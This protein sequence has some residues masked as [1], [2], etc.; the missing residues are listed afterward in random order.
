MTR[1]SDTS[2]SKA[3]CF[4]PRTPAP[5]PDA[6]SPRVSPA[7]MDIDHGH[8]PALLGYRVQKAHWR[9]F[10]MFTDMLT[11]LG[12]APGQYGALL[13]I[14]LNPGLSQVALA[15]ASGI[16][17]TA[18]VHLTRRFDR[19]GWIRRWRR[20]EDRRVYSLEITAAGERILDRA[21]PLIQE[22]ERR[23]SAGLTRAEVDRARTL[24]A[25]I[26]GN[27]NSRT[28]ATRRRRHAKRA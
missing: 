16:D 14:G 13:L 4:R 27:E 6:L 5:V 9:C 24:L 7:G 18:V 11:G 15:D 20:I 23:L 1:R 22:Y 17:E 2:A 10:Q 26:A 12:L 28:E 25:K 21:W 19:L 3:E 8:L